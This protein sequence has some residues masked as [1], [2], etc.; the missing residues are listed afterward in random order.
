MTDVRIISCAAILQAAVEDAADA[1]RSSQSQVFR[2]GNENQENMGGLGGGWFSA[3]KG[4]GSF[5]PAH[6]GGFDGRS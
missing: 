6:L 1:H 4:L 3:E 2:A 5:T